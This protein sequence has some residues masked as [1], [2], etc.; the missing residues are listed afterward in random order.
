MDPLAPSSRLREGA[1][2]RQPI[3]RAAALPSILLTL[4][5]FLE[6]DSSLLVSQEAVVRMPV[7][8]TGPVP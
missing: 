6:G 7:V 1:G 5:I 8:H 4:W 3:P 2:R